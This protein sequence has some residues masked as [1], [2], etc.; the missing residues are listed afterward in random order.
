MTP[1]L[2][3]F[4]DVHDN[5]RYVNLNTLEVIKFYKPG[6]NTTRVAIRYNSGTVIDYEVFNK[7]ADIMKENLKCFT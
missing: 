4:C 6:Y 3:T 7:T 2:L 5:L 1:S